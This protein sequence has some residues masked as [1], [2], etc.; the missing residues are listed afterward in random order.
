MVNITERQ[1]E[2][3]KFRINQI[4]AMIEGANKSGRS[5]SKLKIIA[6]CCIEWGMSRRKILE[7]L[8][9]LLDADKIRLIED[10]LYTKELFSLYFKL[11]AAKVQ[12][13]VPETQIKLKGE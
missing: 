4:L 5:A 2:D 6:Y 12:L 13:K 8:N 11:K 9:L 7:Y 10:E 3:R 1:S